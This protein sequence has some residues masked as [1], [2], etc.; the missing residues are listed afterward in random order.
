MRKILILVTLMT[1]YNILY[2]E[3][4]SHLVDSATI[5]KEKQQTFVHTEDKASRTIVYEFDEIRVYANSPQESAGIV[6]IVKIEDTPRATD[7]TLSDIMRDIPG[8]NITV[9]GRGESNIRIRGFRRENVKIMIDGRQINSGY[10]GNVN[11]AEIPSFDIT[12]IHVVKGAISPLYG[13]NSSGGIVNLITRRPDDQS[14]VTLKTSIQRNNTQNIQ[15]ITSHQFELWDYWLNLSGY[16]TDGFMLSNS[17]TPTYSENGGSRNFSNNKNFNLQSK[18]NFTLFDSHLIGISAGYSYAPKR[19]VPGNIYETRYRIFKD[20]RRWHL[21]CTGDLYLTPTIS[22]NSSMF[23]EAYD[24]IY[25]EYSHPSFEPHFMGL[26]SILENW[27]LGI[28]LRTKYIWTDKNTIYHLYQFEKNAYNRRDNQSYLDWT[29]N[30]TYLHN[31][32]VFLN[33]KFNSCFQSGISVG[34]SKSIRSYKEN[35]FNTDRKTLHTRWNTETSFSLRYENL[36]NYVN[37]A[38]SR[39]IQYPFLQQIYSESR[40]N[41]ELMPEKIFKTEL[42]AGTWFTLSNFILHPQTS[43]YYNIIDDM[44][45]RVNVPRFINQRRLKNCGFEASMT[46]DIGNRMVTEHVLSYINLK[47]NDEYKFYDIPKMIVTNTFNYTIHKNLKYFYNANWIDETYSLDDAG[48]LHLLPAK[49]LQG[50]GLTYIFQK[51]VVSFSISNLF[52]LNHQE[53]WGYPAP[54]RNFTFAL[55]IILF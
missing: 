40:G 13:A 52:D 22:F 46:M 45:D 49:I 20:L 28:N 51:H 27:T 19:N 37:L 3:D 50:T 55:K 39:N 14:W 11:L 43:I 6:S 12:E 17:F 2:S 18:I 42:S 5:D 54:G 41:L 21:S 36:D 24:N 8:I 35:S 7:P 33:H 34:A 23:Y 25:Q 10:F 1:I 9:G 4:T 31:T 48:R 29:S 16:K 15:L 30:P 26:D 53:E 38:V 44:I 32:N 47:M